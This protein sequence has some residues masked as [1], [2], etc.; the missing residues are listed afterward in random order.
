MRSSARARSLGTSRVVTV[1]TSGLEA[2]ISRIPGR[3]IQLLSK[4]NTV[5]KKSYLHPF[6]FEQQ[7]VRVGRVMP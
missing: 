5:S 3:L 7:V 6:K 2:G 1:G 4:L